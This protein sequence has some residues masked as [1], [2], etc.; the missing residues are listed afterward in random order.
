M[1]TDTFEGRL[2]GQAISFKYSQQ[3]V[4]YSLFVVRVVLGWIFLQAGLQKLLA[5]DWSA[6][7][8]L[9]NAI[10]PGNPFMGL[11]STLAGQA[12]VD[13]L[14]VWGQILIGVGLITGTFFRFS[15]LC[16]ALMMIFY[17]MSALQGGLAAGLP[18]EHGWVVDQHLVY[19][20]L[21]FALGA[22]GAG[23]IL[24]VDRLLEKTEIVKNN[25]WL[26]LLLA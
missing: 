7:S 11:W 12:W 4:A 13:I 20:A 10:P 3:W 15:A 17:W 9:Q 6:A 8:Y 16:G 18:L 19:A 26:E 14:N 23:R 24:G 5:A 25:R 22:F 21:L 2:F 1:T